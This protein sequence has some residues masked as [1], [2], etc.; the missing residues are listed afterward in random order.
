MTHFVVKVMQLY[1]G[2]EIQH[3]IV[4]MGVSFDRCS[5]YG[6]ILNRKIRIVNSN[7]HKYL[8]KT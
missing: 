7:L 4:L 1:L 2:P 8:E 6:K 3:I 5:C